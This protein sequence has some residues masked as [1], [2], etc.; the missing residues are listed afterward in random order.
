VAN[1][2]FNTGG[3]PEWSSQQLT[4]SSQPG[5]TTYL[6]PF[7]GATWTTPVTR[8]L[9]LGAANRSSARIEFDLIIIDS[10]DSY[11][12]EWAAVEGDVFQILINGVPISTDAFSHGLSGFTENTR[13]STVNHEGA[14][15]TINMTRTQSGTN[16]TG[17]SWND[18]IWRVT[19][20]IQAPPQTFTLGFSARLSQDIAD[21]AF[22][23]DNFRVTHESGARVPASFTANPAALTG[24]DLHTR[25]RTYSGCPQA[26]IATN[27]LTARNT[28]LSSALT[29]RRR[30]GGTTNLGNCGISGASRF[31]SAQPT[32]V[33][34]YT[35]N[36]T[37]GNGQRLRIRTEDGNSGNTCDATILVLD[38]F[39]QYRWNDDLSGFGWN[40]GLNLGNAPSGTYTVWL[41]TFNSG[42]CLTNLRLE[43]Y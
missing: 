3:A 28:D 31:I 39:G 1:Q 34:N 10:W 41:G 22:G 16:F 9:D 38:P 7:G 15:Y 36:G 21:E 14:I 12:T 23:I 26:A 11:S 20:D 37:G 2:D 32:L 42:T 29:F 35:N 4:T 5:I 18:Q 43:R 17:S 6:G 13:T 40:A 8:V 25:F 19:V 24:T 30:A 27:W 33:F